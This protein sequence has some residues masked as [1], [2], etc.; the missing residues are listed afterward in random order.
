MVNPDNRIKRVLFFSI[1]IYTIEYL[2]ATSEL[3]MQ[4]NPMG[5]VPVYVKNEESLVSSIFETGSAG[6]MFSVPVMTFKGPWLLLDLAEQRRVSEYREEMRLRMK[7]Y[8]LRQDNLRW[9]LD[10]FHQNWHE[11]EDTLFWC[12]FYA[13]SN[14]SH[15]INISARTLNN[16]L[17]KAHLEK[18]AIR[19]SSLLRLANTN[20]LDP[21]E[22][23]RIK[24]VI[25]LILGQNFFE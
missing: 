10:L 13:R 8:R 18:L 19:S 20:I 15:V 5:A 9:S 24:H 11:I 1:L 21:V 16:E 3:D 17:Y 6:K 7:I 25:N 23:E 14:T 2:S 12:S 4:V 22:A